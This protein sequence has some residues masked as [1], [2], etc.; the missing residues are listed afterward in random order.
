MTKARP[1]N[2]DEYHVWFHSDSGQLM[3][4]RQLALNFVSGN[5][6]AKIACLEGD[7]VYTDVTEELCQ[8]WVDQQTHYLDPRYI[9]RLVKETLDEWSEI[10]DGKPGRQIFREAAE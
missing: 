4:D 3:R 10:N 2:G 6:T 8:E 9:P 1:H 5:D 7:G